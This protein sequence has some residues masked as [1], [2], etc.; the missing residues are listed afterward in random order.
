MKIGEEI[1]S[2]RTFPGGLG[3]AALMAALLMAGCISDGGGGGKESERA[4]SK[5]GFLLV[6]AQTCDDVKEFVADALTEEALEN[7]Y[8]YYYRVGDNQAMDEGAPEPSAGA[9]G[10]DDSA[11]SE[12]TETN[13]Q[14]EGV[15]EPDF[16]KTDGKYIYT[17][18]NGE[19]QILKSW[20]AEETARVGRYTFGRA[21][22]PMTLFLKGDTVAVFSSIWDHSYYDREWENDWESGSYDEPYGPDGREPSLAKFSGTR[23]TLLDVSDRTEPT[24]IRHIDV[25]GSYT[26]ARMVGSTAYLVTNSYFSNINSW[27][28]LYDEDL[29]ASIPAPHWEDTDAEIEAKKEEAWPLAR[30]AMVALLAERETEEWLP[31]TQIINS[32]GEIVSQGRLYDCEDLYLPQITAQLGILNI[33]SFDLTPETDLDSTGVVAR[34]WQ[35]Y[36]S[37][38]NIYVS[39]TSGFWWGWRGGSTSHIHKFSLHGDGAVDYRAS[40]QVDGWTLNQFAFSEYEG[41]LRVAT[42]TNTGNNV[43]VLREDQG[44]LKEIG[45][46]RDLA[47]GEQIYAVRYMGDRGYMVTFRQVDPLYSIDLSD[48]TNPV[49]TGELKIDGYSSYMHPLDDD[50]LLTIG[51]DGDSSG[52][53]TGVHLQIFDVSDMSEPK[54]IYHHRIS[55][56]SWSS[57]S[58]AL[59]N[60]LAFTYQP[61]LG[62]LG[63]PMSIWENDARFSG[64][65]L[66]E[67]TVADGIQEIGRVSHDDLVAQEYCQRWD[68]SLDCDPDDYE[69]YWYWYTNMRRSIFMSGEDGQ[70]YV[71]SLSGTGLKVSETFDAA[72]DLASVLWRF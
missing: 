66:F 34:G 56:G 41:D 39:A 31:R 19:L 60:H 29:L 40:G 45:A 62:V 36:G 65:M 20:P 47:P 53:L 58:E 37:Q 1:R 43:F 38:E 5:E 64:L 3:A 48:P 25:E 51:M 8:Q 71:Y 28:L 70:E 67:A 44:L 4:R 42:T 32:E 61:R 33:S 35:V 22:S 7:Y 13:V 12:F 15:D 11:P 46:V 27:S 72:V 10:D 24:L 30:A 26:N 16:V 54:R 49:M 17:I 59:Y 50:H 21:S 23:V 57:H 2:G 63:V 52:M 69:D 9:G 55:T 6:P 68:Y 18:A 14:E